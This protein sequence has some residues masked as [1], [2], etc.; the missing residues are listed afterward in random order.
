MWTEDVENRAA[1]DEP[2][3]D[4]LVT[5]FVVAQFGFGDGATP[6]ALF[7]LIDRFIGVSFKQNPAEMND[8]HAAAHIHDVFDDVRGEDDHDVFADFG[9]KIV[10]TVAFTGIESG[11]G[12]IHDQELGIA[13]KR[14]GDTEALTHATGIGGERFFADVIEIATAEHGFDNV[15][16]LAGAG[17]PLEKGDV[18]EHV[19]RGDARVNAEVLRE[20]TEA[21]AKLVFLAEDVKVAQADG[22]CVGL[23]QGG[24]GAHERSF[25]STIGAEEPIHALGNIE[26]DAIEG[27]DAIRIGLI[28]ILD[29]EHKFLRE[30]AVS[31]LWYE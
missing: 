7:E 21:A 3:G 10:E 26:R 19:L 6:N 8:G 22:A 14:L 11:G 13:D 12:F 20:I 28:Q 23:L 9:E 1:A 15:F 30:R 17:E 4:D 2:A 24:D 5:F 16:A 18:A 27:F 29:R 25:S 31:G